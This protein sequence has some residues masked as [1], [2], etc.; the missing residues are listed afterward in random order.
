MEV[1]AFFSFVNEMVDN[2]LRNGLSIDLFKSYL[3]HQ[4]TFL[5]SQGYSDLADAI[6]IDLVRPER[7]LEKLKEFQTAGVSSYVVAQMEAKLQVWHEAQTS[8]GSK[9]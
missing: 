4:V 1:R 5:R 3:D 7:E 8:V 2:L 9:I 6:T